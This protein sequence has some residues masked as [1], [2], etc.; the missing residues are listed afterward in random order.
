[1]E[2]NLVSISHVSLHVFPMGMAGPIANALKPHPSFKMGMV[3]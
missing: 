3:N 2:I 1:M